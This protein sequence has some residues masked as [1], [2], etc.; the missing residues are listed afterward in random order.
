MSNIPV[1][2]EYIHLDQCNEFEQFSNMKIS[3][4]VVSNFFIQS[5]SN[6]DLVKVSHYQ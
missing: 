6:Y 5:S 3:D 4:E 2:T 1:F